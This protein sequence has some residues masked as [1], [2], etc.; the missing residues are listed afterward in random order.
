MSGGES[1]RGG[2]APGS[3]A[4]GRVQGTG[5]PGRAGLQEG[6]NL[7]REAE[8]AAG[9]RQRPAQPVPG[10]HDKGVGLA[11][12]PPAGGHAGSGPRFETA[13]TRIEAGQT[14]RLG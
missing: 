13:R 3:W 1:W 10:P 6:D 4:D 8:V 2:G 7:G 14:E 11:R 9:I 5:R 12:L